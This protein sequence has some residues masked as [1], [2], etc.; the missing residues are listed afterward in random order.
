MAK[1]KGR[2][3]IRYTSSGI[4][5]LALLL[6]GSYGV[7]LGDF[8]SFSRYVTPSIAVVF[9]A[10]FVTHLFLSKF[11]LRF[12][13]TA[14]D[15]YASLITFLSLV[16]LLSYGPTSDTITYFLQLL[17]LGVG[18]YVCLRLTRVDDEQLR[19]LPVASSFIVLFIAIFGITQV[20][21]GDLFIR[22]RLGGETLNPNG[23]AITLL[24]LV[25]IS[26][27]GARSSSTFSLRVFS[28][29]G[30]LVGTLMIFGAGSRGA[31][32]GLLL[33]SVLLVLGRRPLLGFVVGAIWFLVLLQLSELLG[34]L[35]EFQR[36]FDFT[37]GSILARFEN[38]G[39]AWELLSQRP[40]LGVGMMGFQNA[41]AGEYAH[42][43]YLEIMITFGLPLGGFSVMVLAY[44]TWEVGRKAM[45]QESV[46]ILALFMALLA[47]L[48]VKLFST[49]MAM[50]KDM[51]LLLG[52]MTGYFTT[53]S[54]T[55]Y[56]F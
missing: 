8:F 49:N 22:S 56:E 16:F 51:F 39:V 53:R 29:V 47:C 34:N 31:I 12:K 3:V 30:F 7:R 19:L 1:D 37:G 21:I 42:N 55:N 20:G 44:A 28:L 46:V 10:F 25:V 13:V 6:L 23:L 11:E 9:Y 24:P 17:V 40:G 4:L 38:Y 35:D 50:L 14:A 27:C 5:V 52:V 41:T 36:L 48:W 32:S 18:P 45:K 26:L 33:A 54:R 2:L 43:V 15:I